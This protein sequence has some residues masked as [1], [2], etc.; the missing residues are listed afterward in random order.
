VCGLAGYARLGGG[1]AAGIDPLLQAM[2]GVLGRR[3]PDGTAFRTEGPVGLAFTRLSIVD[4]EHGDQPFVSED[5]TVALIANGEVYN[6][7]ELEAG[8]PAGTRMRTDSDCEVLL[9]LY[10]R[11]GIHFLD[12]VRG[13]YAVVIHDS[14][15]RKLIFARDRFG[16]K[17]LYYHRNAERVV[18]ASE[19][20]A[21]FTD[22]GVPRRLNWQ[23]CLA[24]QMT[25]AS[26]AFELSDPV[27]YFEEIE[28]ATAAQV[29]E[30]DLVSGDVQR[31]AYWSLP[32]FRDGIGA[33]AGELVSA[34]GDA[35]RAAVE[36]SC[37]SD[38]EIGLFL[39]GGV[40]SAAVAAFAQVPGKLHAFTALN[41]GTLANLDGEY[42]HR[43]AAALG[44][45]HHEVVFGPDRY[46]SV[47]EWRDLLWYLESPLCGPEQ[48]YK[49]ELHRFA[50]A[51]RPDMK[52]ML[53]GQASDEFN[54]GYS[55]AL[56][57]GGDWADFVGSLHQMGL[58]SALSAAPRMAAWWEH[59]Y[60]LLTYDAI[61]AAAAKLMADP[62]EG[63][64]AW[65][66]RDIQQYNCWH[67]DRTAAANGIEARVPFLDQRV[68]EVTAAIPAALRAELLW[69]KRILRTAL[70]GVLPGGLLDRPKVSFY[71]GSGERHV[72]R[73]FAEMLAQDGGAL[74]EQALSGP[75]ARQYLHPDGI[76]ATAR[77]LLDDPAGKHVSFLLRAVNLGLLEQ[78]LDESRHEMAG[79]AAPLPAEL[80]VTDWDAQRRDIEDEIL[81][82]RPLSARLVP[83]L[84][85]DVMLVQAVPADGTYYVV[86]EGSI[87]YVVEQDADPCWLALLLEIDGDRDLAAVAAAAGTTIADVETELRAAIDAGVVFLSDGAAADDRQPGDA[88]AELAAAAAGSS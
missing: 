44:L 70:D 81:G 26:P 59:G 21:L 79:D 6:H 52:V 37:M 63:F 35:L 83:A 11:D 32:S 38:A 71:Y 75:Q 43:V 7:R 13:I 42:A 67:E 84:G 34:Y 5:G 87:E 55:E 25:T 65:K 60:P 62:Y 51:T 19:I 46:P 40:D 88:A 80:H 10:Q 17:P 61:D 41:G 33:G 29:T 54:G 23:Q 18:F 30:I 22:P 74:I 9:H 68:V 48:F 2:A 36:E 73:A 15:R 82:S 66:Y 72:T 78:L 64:I 20:K 39:S 49:Y 14:R 4:P 3:G 47:S 56:A 76:R 53:L 50:R 57:E 1:H 58:R 86:V 8:L 69:D 45:A 77:D 31:H 24:D 12:Q 28:S 16:I 85:D 27:T